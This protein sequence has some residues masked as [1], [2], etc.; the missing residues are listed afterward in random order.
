MSATRCTWQELPL[1]PWH[2]GQS[3]G[4]R[5]P[6]GGVSGD[7]HL[8]CVGLYFIGC[9]YLAMLVFVVLVSFFLF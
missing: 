5:S 4:E 9:T 8:R 3:G 7:R 2:A 1:E 6:H